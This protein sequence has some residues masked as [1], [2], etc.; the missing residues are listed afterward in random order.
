MNIRLLISLSSLSFSDAL[1][2]VLIGMSLGVQNLTRILLPQKIPFILL[3]DIG[4]FS[5]ASVSLH[6]C[7]YIEI[8]THIHIFLYV[9]FTYMHAHNTFIP[10][11]LSCLLTCVCKVNLILFSRHQNIGCFVYLSCCNLLS[12]AEWFTREWSLVSGAD[13][14]SINLCNYQI[15]S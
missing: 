14:Y 7:V 8:C 15:N 3:L 11:M 2:W 13:T 4:F 1:F 12:S 10:L 5:Y 6:I 9:Y